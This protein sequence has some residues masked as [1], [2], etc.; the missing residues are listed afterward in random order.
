M[1]ES[2]LFVLFGVIVLIML[3]ID[4]GV[5]NKQAHK[6]TNREALI[7]SIVWIL[8]ALAFSVFIYYYYGSAK[9]SEYLAA[10]LIER[11][12][13]IDNLFVFI[14]I[15]R[16]FAVPEKYHHRVLFW[17]IGGA[18]VLRALFIFSGVWLIQLTYLPP[19][20]LFG[21]EVHFNFVLALF[22]LF[23][24]WAGIKSINAE[25][26][27]QDFS[28]NIGVKLVRKFFPVTPEYRGGKFFVKELGKTLATPLLL[29]V[30]VIEVTDVLFAVDSIPAI[31]AVSKDP[32]ILYTSNIFAILGLRA[33][34]FLLANF[35]DY[36]VYLKYGLAFILSFI[37]VKMLIADFVHISSTLS[38]LIIAA[39][40][41][42]A[43]VT[44]LVWGKKASQSEA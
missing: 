3:I 36:F 23:L 19:F 21:R 14:L 8:V 6:V 35:M 18:I 28:Q 25:D 27:D 20:E 38:L 15:F 11:S 41:T 4:L 22:G 1:S 10:Y 42:I 9:T 29:V 40:L 43:I 16:F 31:F 39:A 5:F 26:D 17:G 7:W 33:L 32:I 24:V 2:F 13:S 34:Y 37:G 30:A 12:L 44:S